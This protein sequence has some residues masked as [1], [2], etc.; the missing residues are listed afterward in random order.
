MWGAS[1]GPHIQAVPRPNRMPPKEGFR[2]MFPKQLSYSCRVDRAHWSYRQV[3]TVVVALALSFGTLRSEL[4]S[5]ATNQRYKLTI[6]EGASTSKRVKKGRVSSQAVVKLTD[7]NDIPV[8]GIAVAF[9]I[10][11]LTGGGAAFASGGFTSIVTT[12]AAGI[13]SSGAFS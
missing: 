3:L 2:T 5:G 13:A 10:P 8:S 4:L 11:Q 9:T 7:E 6:V 1:D 12:N